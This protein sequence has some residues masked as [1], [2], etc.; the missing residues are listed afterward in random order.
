MQMT[1]KTSK[2]IF[3][4]QVLLII[5]LAE[6]LTYYCLN[7][8]QIWLLIERGEWLRKRLTETEKKRGNVWNSAV[9]IYWEGWLEEYAYASGKVTF[10]KKSKMEYTEEEYV[11]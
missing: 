4:S 9:I 3:N 8:I 2:F 5:N 7:R 11:Q 10:L 1:N 6:F